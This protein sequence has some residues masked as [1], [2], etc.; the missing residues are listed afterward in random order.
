[1]PPPHASIPVELPETFAAGGEL[2]GRCAL[3]TGGSR[4]LGL[5][6][7]CALAEGGA[8]VAIAG[9]HREY[10]ESAVSELERRGADAAPVEADVSDAGSARAMVREAA[11]RLGGLDIL[12]NNAGTAV[13]GAP[14]ELDGDSFDRIFGTNVKGVYFASSEASGVMRAGASIV[15]IASLAG[16]IVDVELG[17]YGASKAAVLQLT[18]ILAAAW[19]ARGIR[20]NAVSPGYTDSPLNAHRKADPVRSHAVVSRTPLARWGRPVDVARAVAFLASGAASFVTGQELVVDGG[21][22]LAR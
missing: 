6:I 20:V 13:R 3:V 14:E 18:R 19:G 4:G 9:R 1:M 11:E 16:T 17:A 21:Y 12:V 8:R 22:A 7:A 5:A 10:L 15:N 2:G